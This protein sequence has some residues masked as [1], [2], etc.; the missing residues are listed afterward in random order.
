MNENFKKKTVN[1]RM[2][3]VNNTLRLITPKYYEELK[4]L[5]ANRL[6]V[7]HG[8][9]PMIKY[10]QSTFTNQPLVGAEI[11]VYQGLN[12][13]SI[14]ETLNIK[15]LFLIDPYMSF[16]DGYINF[17]NGSIN[18]E[19]AKDRIMNFKDKVIWITKKS[20]D[21]LPFIHSLLDFVY[22]DGNHSYENVLED[23]VG[24]F[25]KL[26]KGGVIGGHDY[27]SRFLGVVQAANEFANKNKFKLF[28]DQPDWWIVK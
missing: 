7:D 27:G 2:L 3:I 6:W 22:I 17:G 26:A 14:L 9:R 18:F 4:E 13:L 11:G 10:I 24:Y 28:V 5:E 12:S 25:P 23:I 15:K 8:I 16:N 20:Y 1:F 21:A 19:I